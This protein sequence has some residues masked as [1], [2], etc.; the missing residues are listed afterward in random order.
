MKSFGKIRCC[1]V[2]CCRIRFNLIKELYKTVTKKNLIPSRKKSKRI[3][4]ARGCTVRFPTSFSTQFQR[5]R[6]DIGS[7]RVNLVPYLSTIDVLYTRSIGI[8]SIIYT[9][10][11]SHHG[12]RGYPI[13]MFN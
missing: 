6:K 3:V 8:R 11:D 7:I 10:G 5:E 2:Y 13:L 9:R 12:S 4:N 1:L